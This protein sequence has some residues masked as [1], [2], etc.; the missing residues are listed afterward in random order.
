MLSTLLRS[1]GK[2]SLKW[3]A[4]R[5]LS[6]RAFLDMLKD[7]AAFIVLEEAIDFAAEYSD[8]VK[9]NQ[10]SLLVGLGLVG[11]AR[12]PL[13]KLK[14]K[15]L[16]VQRTATLFSKARLG[17]KVKAA[18]ALLKSAK[19]QA[20]LGGVKVSLANGE[21]IKIT[22]Q[23]AGSL[24]I[25]H[26]GTVAAVA[27]LAAGL[28]C[29]GELEDVDWHATGAQLALLLAEHCVDLQSSLVAQEV[30]GFG[31]EQ[32]ISSDAIILRSLSRKYPDVPDEYI[33]AEIAQAFL[34]PEFRAGSNFVYACVDSQG[35]TIYCLNGA[36]LA[37]DDDTETLRPALAQGH[38]E[39][40]DLGDT[41]LGNIL[42]NIAAKD[43]AEGGVE[44]RHVANTSRFVS[45]LF[46]SGEW[47]LVIEWDADENEIFVRVAKDG[48]FDD[49]GGLQ[50][51]RESSM[52][53]DFFA[54]M[55]Q[56]WTSAHL[57]NRAANGALQSETVSLERLLVQLTGESH[58]RA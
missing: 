42:A 56:V 12:H 7:S 25:E 26:S 14:G 54:M 19:I 8:W 3:L 2:Q 48:W 39:D 24:K 38:V 58:E 27:V 22:R 17:K 36:T 51:T 18:G 32:L 30:R 29:S 55:D 20:S 23:A 41:P 11:A 5:Q 46:D 50:K 57:A 21:F 34:Q 49:D 10:G 13:Q 9:E 40:V 31:A 1:A 35:D 47:N 6:R 44:M 15:V 52:S 43:E 28:A 53:E 45:E 33:A 4:T 16:G 37:Y